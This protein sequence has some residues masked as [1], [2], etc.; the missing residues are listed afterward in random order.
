M[1]LGKLLLFL[2]DLYFYYKIYCIVNKIWEF[3]YEYG[4]V[5]GENFM[6]NVWFWNMKRVFMDMRTRLLL[7][8]RVWVMM[9]WMGKGFGW[10]YRI[11]L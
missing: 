10:I 9:E 7:K 4:N 2:L 1:E 6:W 5:F 8:D 3:R 11:V